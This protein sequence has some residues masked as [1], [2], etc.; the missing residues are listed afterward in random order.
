MMRNR[1]LESLID[2]FLS[3]VEKAT[4]LLEQRFGQK[5]ILRLWRTEQIPQRGEIVDGVRYELHGVGCRVYF[6]ELCVDFDYGPEGR[7]DVFDA[8]R[9]YIYACEV[10]LIHPKYTDQNALKL[11]LDEY[12]KIGRVKVVSELTPRLYVKSD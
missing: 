5:C 3:Q 11:D 8:W 7:I 6:P 2:D 1:Y 10:P 4:D 12:V 9:L